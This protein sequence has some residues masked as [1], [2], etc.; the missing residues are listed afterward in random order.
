MSILMHEVHPTSEG[1]PK[2]HGVWSLGTSPN[3]SKVES[4]I[5]KEEGTD[6]ANDL[7]VKKDLWDQWVIEVYLL[8]SPQMVNKALDRIRVLCL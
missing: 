1:V 3:I 4:P 8:V 5:N 7:G 6:K 2:D